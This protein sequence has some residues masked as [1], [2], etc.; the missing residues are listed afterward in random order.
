[1]HVYTL[2]MPY[3]GAYKGMYKN[4]NLFLKYVFK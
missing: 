2:Y 3:T 1:M 4:A